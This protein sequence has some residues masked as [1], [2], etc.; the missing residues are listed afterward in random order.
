MTPRPSRL[1]AT[2]AAVAS[3]AFLLAGVALTIVGVSGAASRAAGERDPTFGANGLVYLEGS[4]MKGTD[5]L[6]QS[7]GRLVIARV[8]AGME[9]ERF[10]TRIG[11]LRSDGA[12]Q[13]TTFTLPD[14]DVAGVGRQLSGKIVAAGTT[15]PASPPSAVWTQFWIARLNGDLSGDETF[16]TDGWREISTPGVTHAKA[17]SLIVRPNGDIF[18]AGSGSV[19]RDYRSRPRVFVLAK[20]R[21]DGGIDPSFGPPGNEGVVYTDLHA[22]TDEWANA[23]AAAPGGKIVLAGLAVVDETSQ[24]ALARYLPDGRLDQS[25]G[26]NGTVLTDFRSS[27]SEAAHAIVVQPDGKIVVAGSAVIRHDRRRYVTIAVARFRTDG[28][29]DP[30]FDDDGK[31]LTRVRT[32]AEATGIAL[33]RDGRIIV[34]GTAMAPGSRQELAIVRYMPDGS[35]DTTFSGDGRHSDRVGDDVYGWVWTADVALQAD[36]KVVVVATVQRSGRP[37]AVAVVRYQG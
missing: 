12:L 37:S 21:R 22:S 7:D 20:R 16:G 23:A 34:V 4:H 17:A 2:S 15:V 8:T 11:R 1:G 9:Q 35:L 31:V 24:F 32:Q 6:V 13:G 28:S 18:V 27:E 29:L 25:F 26:R 10:D 19:G 36:G 14:A 5:V 33:Q 3:A 30:T